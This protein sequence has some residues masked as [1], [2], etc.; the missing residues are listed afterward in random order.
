MKFKKK[1]K[2]NTEET[3]KNQNRLNEAESTSVSQKKEY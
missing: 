2:K 1:K 3:K